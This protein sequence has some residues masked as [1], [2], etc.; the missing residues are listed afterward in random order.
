MKTSKTT[1]L[2]CNLIGQYEVTKYLAEFTLRF[3]ADVSVDDIFLRSLSLLR[4]SAQV[5]V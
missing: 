5:L 1:C 3:G 2:R 4:D